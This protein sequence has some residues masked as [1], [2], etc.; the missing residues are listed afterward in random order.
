MCACGGGPSEGLLHTPSAGTDKKKIWGL[1]VRARV[2]DT[3]MHR[4]AASASSVSCGN[5]LTP[6]EALAD[7]DGRMTDGRC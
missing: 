2:C 6:S 3:H 5:G 1:H 7:G 4:T